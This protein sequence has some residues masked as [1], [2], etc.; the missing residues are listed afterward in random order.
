MRRRDF[1]K[2]S[3]LLVAA[4]AMGCRWMGSEAETTYTN[5][6]GNI[7]FTTKKLL[8]PVSTAEIQ[9]WV[10]KHNQVKVLGTRH[11]F[12]DIADS[13]DCLLSLEK[14]N[15]VLGIDREKNT[16]TVEGG[17]R[18]TE[19]SEY[20]NEQGYALQNLA[21]HAH[22]TVSGAIATGTHG[23]G[24]GNLATQ[25]EAIEFVNGKGELV[26]VAKDKEEELNGLLAGLGAFG[27][28]TQLTLKIEPSFNLRQDVFA[29]MPFGVL[30][31]NFEKVMSSGFS[32]SMFTD[33]RTVT[34]PLVWVKRRVEPGSSEIPDS[35]SF[36][37]ARPME[38]NITT[39]VKGDVAGKCSDQMGV[40]GPW[41]TRLPHFRL[42][43]IPEKGNEFQTE[44]FVPIEHA[45]EAMLVLQGLHNKIEPIVYACEVRTVQ[46]DEQWLSPAYQRN[47]ACFHFTW[48]AELEKIERLLPE[49][50]AGL[51]PFKARPH[52]GKL[53]HMGSAEIAAL[54]PRI[55][56]FRT[57]VKKH[58][59]DGKFANPYLER[60]VL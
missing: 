15:K 26:R 23:S 17:I 2:S 5:W 31:D 43:F 58:D 10:E 12:N 55:N 36:F 11:S 34:M 35:P 28:I 4:G 20:L 14:M 8:K 60:Y 40:S 44:Y 49:I 32:V 54:Y 22:F 24:T 46:A 47:S 56:D 1:V 18:Y 13:N 21:S 53:F 37:D 39:I 48:T 50:E 57:L 25:V 19:L 51:A 38:A 45:Y 29:D 42:D 52:W 9:Q 30:K 7:P 41:H 6:A 27:V 3:T 33:W 59:P 16:V